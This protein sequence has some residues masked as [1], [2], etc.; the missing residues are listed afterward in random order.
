MN[1]QLKAAYPYYL[2][3]EACFANEDLAVTDKYSGEVATKVAMADS[4]IIDHC[5]AIVPGT[6]QVAK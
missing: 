4:K 5:V 3:N 1:G 2:A 6:V